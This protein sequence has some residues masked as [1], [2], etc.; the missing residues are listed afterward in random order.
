MG[1]TIK[2]SNEQI[3]LILEKYN[4][5]WT[6]KAIGELIGGSRSVIKRVL[7]EN[8]IDLRATT[9]KY[10]SNDNVFENIDSSE[11][12]YWLGFIAA[13][14][15]NYIR[16]HNASLIINLRQKDKGHLEKFQKFMETSAI[17]Q[18]YKANEG[19]SNNTPMS[20]IVINSKKLSQDLKDKGIVPNKSLILEPPKI[21]AEY[22]KPYILGYFDGDG[23]IAKSTQHNNYLFSIQ[24]T[25]ETLN[26]INKILNTNM[27]L[28]QRV[29]NPEKNSYYIRCGGTN[30]PY[31]ILKDLYDSCEVHLDRKYEIYKTLETVVLNRNI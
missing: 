27:K 4:E 24:G 20:K 8:Q 25:K 2:L 3:N 10:N 21:S 9:K 31:T 28:E 22:Y 14:G 17:I 29:D 7:L 26:W 19:Y 11:K 5:N 18:D 13:D 1:K 23:S 16:E 15:C 6:Q 12:A 30:K